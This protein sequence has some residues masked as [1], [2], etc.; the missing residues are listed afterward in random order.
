M[1]TVVGGTSNKT[2]IMSYRKF[3][4]AGR[5]HK[6]EHLPYNRLCNS[7]RQLARH[8]LNRYDKRPFP[9][10]M[11]LVVAVLKKLDFAN[12]AN[13]KKCLQRFT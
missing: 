10:R 11:P 6:V 3:N 8:E 4:L 12:V 9:Y 13:V 7:R 2:I 5:S 1:P